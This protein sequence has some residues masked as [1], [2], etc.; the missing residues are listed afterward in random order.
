MT[1]KLPNWIASVPLQSVGV[2]CATHIFGKNIESR[3][4]VLAGKRYFH[5]AVENV[6]G[7]I[8]NPI[9]PPLGA[10]ADFGQGGQ[11]ESTALRH[12][13]DCF[14]FIFHIQVEYFRILA[15]MYP[16]R[17]RSR[18]TGVDLNINQFMA[19]GPTL[20][21]SEKRY[22]ILSRLDGVQPYD[23]DLD[24]NAEFDWI[25]DRVRER[26]RARLLQAQDCYADTLKLS[27]WYGARSKNLI[28]P[29]K[30]I[31][32]D[33]SEY[34]EHL[35]LAAYLMARKR[36]RRDGETRESICFNLLDA[37]RHLE[38]FC[39]DMLRTNVFSIAKYDLERMDA[40][41]VESIL[42]VRAEDDL[43]LGHNGFDKRYQEYHEALHAL[44]RNIEYVPVE[45]RDH[46]F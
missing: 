18:K 10:G 5:N 25:D 27:E 33:L 20:L 36:N 42:R 23:L 29:L 22:L 19:K 38:R 26:F 45:E 3:Q 21:N 17:L 39:L 14:N 28:L 40:K 7:Y 4:I 24:W 35:G 44:Y 43:H 13:L 30:I 34:F 12:I 6:V 8:L 16:E 1:S 2:L 32:D 37:C 46:A 31:M 11:E 9:L 41:S 15:R